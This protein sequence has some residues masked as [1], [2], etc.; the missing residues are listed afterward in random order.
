MRS[1]YL[2]E[3]MGL[4]SH[5]VNFLGRIEARC[6]PHHAAAHVPIQREIG[7]QGHHPRIFEFALHLKPGMTHA[8]AQG[9]G[10]IGVSDGAASLFLNDPNC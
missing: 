1:F 6:N 5:A 9:F 10:F 3:G 4:F 7:T 2:F 8:N